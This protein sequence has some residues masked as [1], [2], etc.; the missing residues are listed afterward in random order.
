M[1]TP[2]GG[3]FCQEFSF[4]FVFRFSNERLQTRAKDTPHKFNDTGVPQKDITPDIKQKAQPIEDSGSGDIP[5]SL[6]VPIPITVVAPSPPTVIVPA[7]Q[8]QP[9]VPLGNELSPLPVVIQPGQ[10]AP[11]QTSM[12]Y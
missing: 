11:I 7:S 4:F 12:F 8:T 5:D 9:V 3:C 6:P 10:A 2:L 1:R